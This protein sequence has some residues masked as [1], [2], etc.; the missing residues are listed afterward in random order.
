MPDQ[1]QELLERLG[2]PPAIAEMVQDMYRNVLADPELAP[3]FE[4]ASME[5]LRHMQYEFLVSAL[6]GPV[7]YTGAELTAVHHGR[8]ITG[9][10][11]ALFCGH[12]ATAMESRGVSAQDV[13][14]TLSRLA[15][16]KDKVTGD[17]N[18]GG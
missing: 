13:D 5:R 18:F 10:H 8:G 14:M 16:Y 15:M 17:S 4:K 9:H 12:F 3:F 1:D 2:G 6:S 11:F 7:A